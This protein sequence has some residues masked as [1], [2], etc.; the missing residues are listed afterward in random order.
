MSVLLSRPAI[1][2]CILLSFALI[3]CR[4]QPPS[5]AEVVTQEVTRLVTEVVTVEA[6]PEEV[7]RVVEEILEVTAVP[8]PSVPPDRSKELTV[9]LI[10]EPRTLYL[11]DAPQFGSPDLAR[12]AVLH[13]IYEN[14]ITTLSF[15]YQAQGV[16]KLPDFDDSD[17]EIMST[18]VS[19]GDRVVDVDGEVVLLSE[20]TVIADVDGNEIV[21][22]GTPVRMPQLVVRFSLRPMMW[23]DGTPVTA[24]DS[25]FSF[26]VASDTITPGNKTVIDRTASY[27]AIDQLTVEWTG[28]PGWLDPTYFTN[29]WSPLPVHQLGQLEVAE[30]PQAFVAGEIPL[31]NGPFVVAEWVPGDHISMVRNERYYRVDES[32]PHLDGLTFRFVQNGN[33]LAALLLAGQCDVGAQDGL[34]ISLAPLLMEAQKNGLLAL[35][36]QINNVFEHIDFGIDPAESYAESRPD[37]FENARVRQAMAM[38]TDRQ[39][40]ID[41]ALLGLSEIAHSYVPTIHPVSPENITIWPYDVGAANDL[42]DDAGYL[43]RDGDGTREDPETR[44]PFQVELGVNLS[45]QMRQQIAQ[46]FQENMSDCGIAVEISPQSA[47]AWFAPEGPLFGRRFDLALFPWIMGLSPACDLYTTPSIPTEANGWTGNNNT[48]WS[49]VNYDAACASAQAAYV[50]TDDYVVNHEAALRIFAEQVPVIPL[51]SHLKVAAASPHVLNFAPDPTQASALWNL[52]EI[53]VSAP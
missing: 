41:Q 12:Q 45:S 7:T 16:E 35:S 53:D 20:G 3:G 50:G 28:I 48:G 8:T 52:F 26:Q 5:T 1:V 24:A 47:A 42:L 46:M 51:F 17:A 39:A 18:T 32:L 44:L 2:A 36:F 33:E 40:M 43:D 49:D 37:W 30:L 4:S 15:E 38:C 13:A 11:Y 19:E 9:C 14:L 27:R 25:L 22:D 23:S 6:P 21:F 10:N 29:I 34:E 31:S